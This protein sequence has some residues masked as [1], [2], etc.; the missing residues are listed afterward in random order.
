TAAGTYSVTYQICENLNPTNCDTAVVTVEVAAAALVATDDDMSAQTVGGLN[1]GTLPS[2]LTN[3][4]LGGAAID[5]SD[6][7]ISLPDD[8]G[9]GA[10]IDANGVITIPAGTPAGTYTIVYEICEVL[11]PTNCATATVTVVVTAPNIV[12][13]DDDFSDNP[14]NGTDGGV[15]GNILTNDTIDGNPIQP[16]QVTI[17]VTDDAG[18]GVTIAPNGDVIVAPG[19]PAGT[20]TITYEICDVLNPSNCATGTV[21]IV[22]VEKAILQLI[23]TANVS[24]VS[25]GDFVTYTV[26]VENIGPVDA[27]DVTVVDTPPIGMS[28]VDGSENYNDSNPANDQAIGGRPIRFEGVDVASGETITITYMMRIGATALQG[29]LINSVVATDTSAVVISN[30][31]TAT[32]RLKSDPDFEQATIMGKVFND[33]DGDGWQDDVTATGLVVTGGID[34]SAYVANSTTVDRGQGP[35]PEADAS[36]PINH[37]IELG[38]LSGRNSYMDKAENHQMVI[39]QL[40]TEP[41]FTNDFELTTAQGTVLRMDATGKVTHDH[42]GEVADGLSAQELDIKRHVSVENGQYRVDYVIS[43]LG[44]TERGIPGVRIATV[45]GYIIE[46]D[47]YGRF[48]LNAIEVDNFGRGQNFIMKVDPATLPKGSSFTTENPRVKRITQ[49]MPASFDFGIKIPEPKPAASA[50][51]AVE[52][53]L[54][55]IL[56]E[57]NSAEIKSSYQPLLEKMAAKINQYEAGVISFDGHGGGLG[58]AFDRAIKVRDALMPMVNSKATEN[59]AVSIMASPEKAVKDRNIITIGDEI[60]LGSIMFDLN[61]DTVKTEY[62]AILQ[63]V[64]ERFNQMGGGSVQL[65]GHTDARADNAY[66]YELGLR[67]ANNVYQELMKYI[68]K[69]KVKNVSVDTSNR[70]YIKLQ[71]GVQ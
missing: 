36:A 4:T 39:S 42:T 33:R 34:E 26:T 56:F 35:Q 46:T 38:T 61:K 54:G 40:M 32:I 50:P 37:G 6:V 63:S 19:T 43:N 30:V 15:A 64:A 9:I 13:V 47:A 66:N 60:Q 59:F 2:V 16:G 68:D 3:D 67:R 53:E 29:S 28:L 49:G 11:N 8:G 55:T 24:E 20:Y 10:T 52:I 41:R 12:V 45:E 58:I 71:G 17:T 27:M 7:T 57:D 25:I 5:P 51:K 44:I 69:T 48:H 14:V 1:G 22:V 23:K 65:T 62:Q 70:S 18:S 21:T 31:A